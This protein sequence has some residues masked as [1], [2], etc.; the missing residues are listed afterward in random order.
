MD[1]GPTERQRCDEIDPAK[2]AI[3]LDTRGHPAKGCAFGKMKA[4]DIEPEIAH[5]TR[6]GGQDRAA[7][8]DR[9]NGQQSCGDD[10][11]IPGR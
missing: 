6:A 3:I 9:V 1:D 7:E 11:F 4:K 2:Q 8:A 10:R 5:R